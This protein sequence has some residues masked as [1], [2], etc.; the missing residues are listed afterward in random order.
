M[1]HGLA[2]PVRLKLSCSYS[3]SGYFSG[4][5][6]SFYSGTTGYSITT[7]LATH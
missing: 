6:G 4:T 7:G 1:L 2:L 5:S 3:G